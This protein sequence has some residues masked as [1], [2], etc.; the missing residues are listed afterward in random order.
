MKKH[1][2]FTLVEVLMATGIMAIVGGIL[3]TT[4]WHGTILFARN[5][6]INIA[7]SRRVSR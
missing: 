3:F 1:A 4:L 5:T 2:G 6:A 7:T